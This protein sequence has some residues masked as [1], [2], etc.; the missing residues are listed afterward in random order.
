MWAR[1][2]EMLSINIWQSTVVVVVVV[3]VVWFCIRMHSTTRREEPK[4]RSVLS[5]MQNSLLNLRIIQI[6]TDCEIGH[7]WRKQKT[8]K[9]KRRKRRKREPTTIYT[10]HKNTAVSSARRTNKIIIMKKK[11]K[12]KK[13]RWALFA[14][15][16]C[17]GTYARSREP[18]RA[19][20]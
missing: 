4:S 6:E 1:A 15:C 17:S 7:E 8:K 16:R 3:V 19:S 2:T 12:E 5:K 11:T 18:A 20:Q 9:R 13:T 10:E 14:G